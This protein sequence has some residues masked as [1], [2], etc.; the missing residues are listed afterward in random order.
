MKY[1]LLGRSGLEV[2]EIC[3]GVMSFTGKGGW[4]H[5]AKIGQKE[6]N[7]LTALAIDRGVNFF[8]TA[9]IYSAG[10]S[11]RML[12]RALQGKRHD[13]VIASKCGLKMSDKPMGNGLSRRH[14]IEACEAS[15]NRLQTDYIDLYQI[16]SF[17]F[18]VPLEETIQ[19]LDLLVRQ[20]K[21]RYLG[22]SNFSGWQLMKTMALCEKYR[23]QPFI[24]LQAYY[25]LVGRELEFELVPA[26]LDQGLGIMPWSP[27]HG[28]ILS[29]KY[30]TGKKWPE[31]TRIKAPGETLPYDVRRGEKIIDI[32]GKIAVDRKKTIAQVALNYLLQK[33]AV[34]SLVIGARNKKQ[35]L[36]NIAACGWSLGSTEMKQLDKVS[37]PNKPYPQ[38]YFELFR[39]DRL[40]AKNV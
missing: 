7:D 29:G 12:G 32:L 1:R 19:T 38:W 22:L 20:G 14:I 11:E 9:D 3:F 33:P 10:T 18:L 39:K 40:G 16:H 37:E 6:A 8:D 35:L 4:E 13:V 28:G 2:S 31:N 26:C 23:W 27:L 34:S 17:D 15:L 36:E 25:S 30:L 24:S 21:V 5:V